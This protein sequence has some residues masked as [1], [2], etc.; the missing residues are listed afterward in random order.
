MSSKLIDA[1]TLI[2]DL[3]TQSQAA[4]ETLP[5]RVVRVPVGAELV[6]EGDHPSE[7]C[8]L[9]QG[10]LCRHKELDEG[11]RQIL[12]FHLPGEIPDLQ[13][14]HL[15]TMDHGLTALAPS[16]VAYIPHGSVQALI[17][18][19]KQIAAALWRAT[20][21]DASIFRQWLASVGRSDAAERTAHLIC[22]VALRMRM[23]GLTEGYEFDLPLTQTELADALGMSPVHINRVLQ[24]LRAKGLIVTRGRHFTIGDWHQLKRL[25]KFDPAYLHFRKPIP[26]DFR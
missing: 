21:I 20:L 22:E 19:N 2:A 7:C 1:L 4:L 18:E 9:Q 13:S 14:L 11:K 6:R 15:Q 5:L 10:F 24:D 25:A 8:L 26:G 12:S 23:L 16:T 17:D 3:D